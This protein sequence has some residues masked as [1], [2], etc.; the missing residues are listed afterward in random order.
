M[1]KTPYETLGVG[2]KASK[3]TVTKA[4]RKRARET[5]PDREGSPE[6]FNEVRR[7]Y[8]VL[9]DDARR[10]R[11]DETGEADDAPDNATAEAVGVLGQVFLSVLQT[12][13]QQGRD[14]TRI[15]LMAGMRQVL[16]Q[17]K[18]EMAKA[19]KDMEAGRDKLVA[20]AKRFSAKKGKTN[21]LG[22]MAA[23]HAGQVEAQLLNHAKE[24]AKLAKALEL[25]DGH[26][27]RFD[28]EAIM[29]M[30]VSTSSF[31]RY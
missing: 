11:Y 20:A 22:M 6:E 3:A 24:E 28:A 19:R 14:P 8:A 16:N 17:K 31:V 7:A 13:I 23:L 5:H 21:H 9:S 29:G 2:K 18:G 12:V 26:D 25:L 30:T 4:Y 1:K 15:D 10:A 27:Y